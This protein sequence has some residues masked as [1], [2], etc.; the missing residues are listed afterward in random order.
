[1]YHNSPTPSTLFLSLRTLAPE[2][3]D[4]VEELS[5]TPHNALPPPGPTLRATIPL[6]LDTTEAPFN[7]HHLLMRQN[8]PLSSSIVWDVRT[9]PY[10]AEA[11]S[12]SM[13]YRH[14]AGPHI[15][16]PPWLLESAANP[17]Q[18]Y[19]AVRGDEGCHIHS[20][21]FTLYPTANLVGAYV[22]ILDVLVGVSRAG[23]G[24]R[25]CACDL[26]DAAPAKTDGNLLFSQGRS[27]IYEWGG[28]GGRRL[29]TASWMWAG[30]GADV[31]EAGVWM[32]H[33][34]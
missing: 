29:G 27:Q 16:I 19:I 24:R 21:I 3:P 4:A 12:L 30:L 31:M 10:S 17:P 28:G 2:M 6:P 7:L 8:P 5:Y 14:L 32:L 18:K 33:L 11:P 25:R 9:S 23:T 1:M 13:H 34:K 15:V 26:V 20:S 22:T